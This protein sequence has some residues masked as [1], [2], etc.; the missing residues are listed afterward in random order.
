MHYGL[1][2]TTGETSTLS[3][4]VGIDIRVDGSMY[5][6]YVADSGQQ[7]PMFSSVRKFSVPISEVAENSASPRKA[8]RPGI[9]PG[10]V[11]SGLALGPDGQWA[12]VS[13]SGVSEILKIDFDSQAVVTIAGSRSMALETE[14]YLDGIGTM[15]TFR[16]PIGIV[17][18]PGGEYAL[19]A[20]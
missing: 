8:P 20:E 4:P 17:V 19:I 10:C 5:N 15:A 9:R 13:C 12:I 6:I 3:S 18:S 16:Y 2:D 1:D 7:Q 14:G 11:P